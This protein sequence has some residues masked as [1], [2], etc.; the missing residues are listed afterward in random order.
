LKKKLEAAIPRYRAVLCNFVVASL[1][2]W[3]SLSV[4]QQIRA[5]KAS[6]GNEQKERI[7]KYCDLDRFIPEKEVKKDGSEKN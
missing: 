7:C 3:K 2:S 5:L 4:Q 1:P 6:T